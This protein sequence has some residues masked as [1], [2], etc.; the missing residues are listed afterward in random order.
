MVVMLF[1][2]LQGYELQQLRERAE[3]TVQWSHEAGAFVSVGKL[4][5]YR[6]LSRRAC[7]DINLVYGRTCT[8][9]PARKA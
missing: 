4:Y 9:R 7:F 6:S 2:T 5:E 1:V 3:G 8:A